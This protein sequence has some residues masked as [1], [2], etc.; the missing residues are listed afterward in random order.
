MTTCRFWSNSVMGEL[1]NSRADIRLVA[2]PIVTVER[3]AKGALKAYH[4][5]EPAQ[6][7][8][9]AIRESLM[10]IHVARIADEDSR[11]DLGRRLGK[12]LL[13]VRRAVKDWKAMRARLREA[14]DDLRLAP[15][16][17]PQ[18][19]IDEAIAFIEWLEDDN[20]TFLGLR[21]YDFVGGNTRG[22]LRRADTPGLGIL[23]DPSVRVLRRGRELLT[24][25][26]VVRDFLM[27]P[28]AIIVAKANAQTTVHRRAYMD[29]VGVKR[30]GKGGKLVGEV[31][32]VGLFTSTAYTRSTR[33][34]P[35]LRRKIDHVIALAGYDAD[36]HSGKA[37]INVLESYPRDELFQIDEETLFEFAAVVLRLGEHPRVRALARRDKF[38]RFVSVIVFVPRERYNSDVRLKIGDYLATAFNGRVSA[39]YPAFPEGSLARVHFI[40]GRMAGETPNPS[41]AE[42]ETAI[43]GIVRTWSDELALALNGGSDPAR[44]RCL[45]E[46]YGNA[47]P[48]AYRESFSAESALVDINTI[49]SLSEAQPLAIEFRRLPASTESTVELKLVHL[50]NAIA[51]SRRVPILEHMGFRVIDERTYEIMP[52]EGSSHVH[53]HDM[54]L[55]AEGGGAID[56]GKIGT[57]LTACFMATWQ[58]DAESDGYNALVVNAGLAWRDIALLRAISRFLRQAGS[59]YSQDYLWDS[60]NR[61][62]DIAAMLVVL[63]HARFDPLQADEA[64]AAKIATQIEARLEDVKSLDED[65]II[66]R[67]AGVVGAITRTN[68]FQI[69]DDG[70]PHAEINFKID[71]GTLEDLPEPKPFREIFVYSPRVEG[72]HLRFGKVARGGIRWSDRPQDFRTEILGLAKAQQVKNAVIVP[73]GAKGGFVP[74]QMPVG[75]TREA[76]MAEGIAAYRIFISSLLDITDNLDGETIVPPEQVVR[77]EDDD[78]YLVV[79]ADKGTATFSDIANGIAADHGYWLDDAFASGG[80]AGYDHKKMGITARGAWEAVKR[81]FRELDRDIQSDP[82]TVV[83]VGDMSGDVFGNGML[84]SPATKLIAAFDHR[85]IFIDPN[86][87]PATSL[88]ERWRLFRLARSS[89][90]DYDRAKISKG[91]GVFSRKEKAIRLTPEIKT[92][93]DI[94]AERITP[95]ELMRAIL[96]ARADLLWF[97]GIGTFVKAAGESDDAVGDRA[98][99][100]VRITA[101]ALRVSVVGE[102]ANLGMT[103]RAR[104]EFGQSGGRCNTDAID[105]SAGVN[106]SDVEVNIKIALA[107]AVRAGRLTTEKRNVLLAAMTKDVAELVLRNNY[108]QPLAISLSERRGFEDFTFQQRLMQSLEA[109]GRLDREVELLPDDI[110]MAERQASNRPLA[111]AEIAVLLAYAKIALF[112]DLIASG[113]TD[114]PALAAELVRYFPAPMRKAYAGE[115]GS[116]RLRSEIISTM[117]A[118]AMIN[119]G[120]PTYLVRM[121]DRTGAG[122]AETARAYVAV[123]DSFGLQQIHGEIDALD[124]RVPGAVQLELYRAVQDL[125]LSRSTWFLRH[126]HFD[127]GVGPIVAGYSKSVAALERMLASVL[128]PNARERAKGLAGKFEA[129]GVPADL[130][131]RVASLTDLADAT[132]IHLI[133]IETGA[134][135]KVAAEMFFAVDARFHVSRI[136][137]LAVALPANDYYDGLALDQALKMLTDAHRR[138]AVDAIA[139]EGSSPL[140]IWVSLRREAVDRVMQRV[141][142]LTESEALTVSRVAVLAN[143]IA[144]L[145]GG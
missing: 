45:S 51:L 10:Q 29:Y 3:D 5:V 139:M 86:P 110:A 79:A 73:V 140:D 92:I 127:E 101:G 32:L 54:T 60:L 76:I 43:E 24:S 117:L 14:A 114:D 141:A 26:P 133:A 142:A 9:K 64:S 80:S 7:G 87:D 2:H 39:Y 21:E 131:W 66:R 119:R 98:N 138:I 91:G 90:Q 72:V 11:A 19:G 95:Q 48:I 109:E 83:G 125:I 116:H 132:D 47:F 38:D 107:R 102:G 13:E 85:D 41:Q 33:T 57:L 115:I 143:L 34:I 89:W 18:E 108:L 27:R 1:Q 52:Q 40:I 135:L 122:V 145:A 82:F 77:L 69:A 78:P 4:G 99:D 37:L 15:P 36:S 74:K 56:L 93:L 50:H 35:Y 81:H 124:N 84:L 17:V 70:N 62:A 22:E 59:T 65:R 23:A 12:V 97:G 130:A 16:T 53:I 126:V 68:F 94:S 71:S 88:R 42:L 61:H 112:D 111:R 28:E 44:A 30:F 129:D 118:N 20:F 25:T 63:F 46:R 123:R 6:A 96:R 120:G 58:R 31:R 75:G 55:E 49:E 104:V 100:G 8:A 144:D 134:S 67:F 103:Q 105:N 137:A 128:P 121:A 113:V 106:T 136:G